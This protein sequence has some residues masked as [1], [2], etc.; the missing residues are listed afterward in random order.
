MARKKAIVDTGSYSKLD[1]YCIWLNEYYGSLIRAGFR[2][3][4]ALSM[5]QD[6]GTFPDWV[7]FSSVT[8]AD[9]IKHME[10]EEE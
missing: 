9:V 10:E 8:K 7:D 2:P 6:K 4:Y 3:E 5:I 1:E